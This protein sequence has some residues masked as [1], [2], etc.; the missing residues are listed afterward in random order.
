MEIY[1]CKSICCILAAGQNA[2]NIRMFPYMQE[3]IS[4]LKRILEGDK[5]EVSFQSD[6]EVLCC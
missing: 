4:K 6:Q 5:S 2:N 3:G 1:G